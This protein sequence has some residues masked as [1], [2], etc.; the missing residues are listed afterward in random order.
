MLSVH[1]SNIDRPLYTLEVK[2]GEH[3]SD[4]IVKR[5]FIFSRLNAPGVNFKRGQVDPAFI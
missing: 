4:I 3:K 2:F 1:L 5:K